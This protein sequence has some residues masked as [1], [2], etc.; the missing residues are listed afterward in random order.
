MRQCGKILQSEQDNMAHMHCMLV[1][2]A[3][4]TFT[5]YNIYSFPAATMVARTHPDFGNMFF[6]CTL[7]FT[8]SEKLVNNIWFLKYIILFMV[9]HCNY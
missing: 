5:V 1:I 2:K 9:V 8:G 3:T 4:Q 6:S 7:L